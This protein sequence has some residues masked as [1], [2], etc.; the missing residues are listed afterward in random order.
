MVP[1]SKNVYHV[2]IKSGILHFWA[3][4]IVAF[5]FRGKSPN[6]RKTFYVTL[7][8]PYFQA[9]FPIT[10]GTTR[11]EFASTRKLTGQFLVIS[12]I[13]KEFMDIGLAGLQTETGE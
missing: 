10:A 1:G 7:H 4:V 8:S 2:N 3:M 12:W 9:D 6:D 11:S 5:C 13:L